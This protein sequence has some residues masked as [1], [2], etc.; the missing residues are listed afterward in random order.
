MAEMNTIRSTAGVRAGRIDE[1]LRA[2]MN[3]VYGIMSVGMVITALSSWAIA[4]LSVTSEPTQYQM[5]AN[6]YLTGFGYAMYA[7]PLKWLVMFAP[8]IFVFAFSAGINRMSAATAQVVFYV[9][10]AVMGVSIS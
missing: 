4:G 3:K 7:S 8:L 9:F 6:E 2:H 1:G 10:A 5:G